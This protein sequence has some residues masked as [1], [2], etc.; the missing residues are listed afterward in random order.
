M[1]FHCRVERQPNCTKSAGKPYLASFQ[2]PAVAA[3]SLLRTAPRTAP[4]TFRRHNLLQEAIIS[5]FQACV[6]GSGR[7]DSSQMID[8]SHCGRNRRIV[9]ING[10][11]HFWTQFGSDFL[12]YTTL[13]TGPKWVVFPPSPLNKTE[14]NY[15][16][17]LY[18]RILTAYTTLRKGSCVSRCPFIPSRVTPGF[19]QVGI[20]LDDAAGRRV[21]SGISRFPH[22]Y[23][24]TLLHSHLI[25][26]SLALK[27]SLLNHAE[28]TQ[29]NLLPFYTQRCNS[30]SCENPHDVKWPRSAIEAATRCHSIE[31]NPP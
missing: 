14:K 19:S 13:N 5:A 30:T 22:R 15:N 24:P 11:R 16:G 17:L 18:T 23:V 25:S 20:L 6:L 31:Q 28:I 12:Q 1:A 29:L 7:N 26:L 27:T 21:F 3:I 8:I 10:L 2:D 9:S 4:L